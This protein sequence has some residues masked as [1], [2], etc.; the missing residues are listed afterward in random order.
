MATYPDDPD[1]AVLAE[2]AAS[3][4]DMTR[5]LSIDFP[6]VAIDEDSARAISAALTAAGYDNEVVY[7]SGEPDGDEEY[8]EEEIAPAWDVYVRT[9]MVP[10]YDA[11]VG[12]QAQ[13]D[14]IAG[15]LGGQCDGWGVML[16]G[17]SEP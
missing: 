6:V 10:D 12:I 5:P 4:V 7:D 17:D 16:D 11:I 2:L 15:P 8:D 3:G 14:Q 1:G 9:R 13:L